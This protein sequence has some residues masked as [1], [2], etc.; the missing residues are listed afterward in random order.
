M[1]YGDTLAKQKG[2]NREP[3]IIAGLSEALLKAGYPN[4]SFGGSVFENINKHIDAWIKLLNGTKLFDYDLIPI[5]VKSTESFTFIN[6]NLKDTLK[7]SESIYIVFEYSA[8]SPE[9]VFVKRTRLMEVMSKNPPKVFTGYDGKSKYF[10]AKSYLKE[11]AS[12]FN[13]DEL[14]KIPK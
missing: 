7:T 11:N 13:A 4:K 12:G 6:K 9:Y 1:S 5:D 14:F 10:W 2:I 8:D 3:I